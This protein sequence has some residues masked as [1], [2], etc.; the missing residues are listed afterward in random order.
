MQIRSAIALSFCLAVVGCQSGVQPWGALAQPKSGPTPTEPAATP[1]PASAPTPAP[2]DPAKPGPDDLGDYS[3]VVPSLAGW[4]FVPVEESGH[5]GFSNQYELV[6]AAG[7]AHVGIF[8]DAT[9][10]TALEQATGYA[11]ELHTKGIETGR[12]K[13]DPLLACFD[14][15]LGAEAGAMCVRIYHVATGSLSVQ[16]AGRW[17]VTN[18][19]AARDF[20]QIVGQTDLQSN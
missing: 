8:A 15:K 13:S 19:D 16:F 14:V 20:A 7:D 12:I 10:G 2:A 3:L 1:K 18:L 6:N 4:E 11:A 5:G 17:P 9:A